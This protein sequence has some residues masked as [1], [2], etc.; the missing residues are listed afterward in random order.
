MLNSEEQ[1]QEK[2]YMDTALKYDEMHVSKKDEHFFALSFM[3]GM[4]DYLGVK[5]VLDVGSGTGRAILFLK[6]K[7]PDIY[8]VGIEP[9]KELRTVGFEK[10]ITKN[11]LIDGDGSDLRFKDGEFDLV[12]EFGVLHHIKHPKTVV[13]EILR[14]ANKAVFIS[15]SNIYGDGS[16][17]SRML[18]QILKAFYLWKV[19]V[20]FKT[21]GKGYIQSDDDGISYYYSVFDSYN[22]IKKACSSVHFI[23]TNIWTGA[24]INLYRTTNC[25]GLLGILR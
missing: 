17:F 6:E 22:Q 2:Y 7:R 19:A 18:K 14:V 3:V 5:S 9:V 25:I 15:D 1:L 8:I 21:R 16:I 11:E 4:L 12:C 23:N 20:F 24:K 13:S 10:G